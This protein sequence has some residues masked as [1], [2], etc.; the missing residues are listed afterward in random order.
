MWNFSLNTLICCQKRINQLVPSTGT[1]WRPR[2][3]QINLLFTQ[4]HC[5][6]CAVTAMLRST[7]RQCLQLKSN[8]PENPHLNL[9][10]FPGSYNVL[11]LQNF[12][13]HRKQDSLTSEGFTPQSTSV[14]SQIHHYPNVLLP[15]GWTEFTVSSSGHTEPPALP[16]FPSLTQSMHQAVRA[17]LSQQPNHQIHSALHSGLP[18]AQPFTSGKHIHCL[19]TSPSQHPKHPLM[20]CVPQK[21]DFTWT[22]T[23]QG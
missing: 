15:W 18:L 12:S 4:L 22:L 2:C 14:T 21:V 13:S 10:V 3:V 5:R 17:P 20:L 7:N 9:N 19:W 23:S 1:W 6:S 11:I 8:L 16:I